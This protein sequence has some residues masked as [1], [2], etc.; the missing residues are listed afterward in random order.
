MAQAL[1]PAAFLVHRQQQ[2]RAHGANRRTE[3]AHLAR[4]F[5]IAGKQDQPGH[6][7][8]A[9]DLAVLGGQPG[10]LHVQHQRTIQGSLH[11]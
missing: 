3:F 2:I 9:Q 8:L 1:H 10:A 6:L 5:D 4:V 11:E 7:R